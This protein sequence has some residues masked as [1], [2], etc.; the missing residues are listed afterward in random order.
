MLTVDVLT[1]AEEPAYERY[2]RRHDGSLVYQSLKY[3]RFLKELLGCEEQ[4]LVAREGGAIRGILPLMWAESS[5]GRV[6]NSLPYYGSHGGPLADCPRAAGALLRAYA[7]IATADGIASTT[8]IENPFGTGLPHLPPHTHVDFRLGQATSLASTSLDEDGVPAGAEPSARRNLRKARAEGI[9]VRIEPGRLA[10]LR[11]IHEENMAALGGRAKSPRFFRLLVG[12]FQA[13]EDFD[14]Y[15]AERRGAMVAGLL[16][17]YFNRTV[18]YFMPA[19]R[20]DHRSSQPLALILAQA[21]QDATRRGF[22]RWNWGGTWPT[23]TGVFRFKRKWGA[24]SQRY[25]YYTLVGADSLLDLR[26]AELMAVCPHFYV[27]PIAALRPTG[28]PA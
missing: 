25:D 11:A 13:G 19:V 6:Y 4:Y 9:A 18:E 20:S 17:L 21:M 16:V 22:S 5:H 2:L 23:Q 12:C 3:K 26:P 7:D 24:V 8:M 15:V 1:E 27:A 28:V 14:L 10:E